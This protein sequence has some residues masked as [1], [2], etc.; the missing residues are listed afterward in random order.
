M[1]RVERRLLD[2]RSSNLDQQWDGLVCK[3][4]EE[5]F[6]LRGCTLRLLHTVDR[7]QHRLDI[8]PYQLV[9]RVERRRLDLRPSNLDQQWDGLVG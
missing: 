3:I 7:S 5:R 9:L 6:W 8:R 1:L 4:R 2:L